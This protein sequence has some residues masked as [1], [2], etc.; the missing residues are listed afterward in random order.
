MAG[1]A[2]P[3]TVQVLVKLWKSQEFRS[4]IMDVFTRLLTGLGP[5]STSAHKDIYKCIK[6]GLGDK[7]LAVRS[8]SAKVRGMGCGMGCG[9][10]YYR[11]KGLESWLGG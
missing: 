9:V 2:F 11:D 6:S 3:E 7:S 1:S 10:A 5:S 8:A 4:D